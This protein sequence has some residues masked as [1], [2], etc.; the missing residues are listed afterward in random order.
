MDTSR[1]IYGKS[2]PDKRELARQMRREM[3]S[4]ERLLWQ[5]LRGS[6]LGGFHFRRQQVIDGYIAD[7]YCH[8]AG[9]VIE[10]DGAVHDEQADW[11]AQRDA[12][13]EDRQLV[14][15]RFRNEQVFTNMKTVLAEIVRV[16]RERTAAYPPAPSPSTEGESG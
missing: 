16:A 9:L 15:L 4:E 8:R 2:N 13:M 3:T 10:V 12:V 11:D 14:V 6:Q 7:F 5:R 1:I